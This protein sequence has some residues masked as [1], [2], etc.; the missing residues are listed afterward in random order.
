[1]KVVLL[2]LFAVLFLFS[3]SPSTKIVKS[4]RD[5]GT[6]I[7]PDGNR[8]IYVVAMVK[9]EGSRRVIEDE[10]VSRLKKG[11]GVA[12][13][14]TLTPDVMKNQGDSTSLGIMLRN[15]QYTDVILMRLVDVEKELSYVPGNTSGFYGGYGYYYGYSAM[16]YSTPGYYTTDK[17]YTVETTVYSVNPDKLVWTGTT[18]T[19]NPSNTKKAINDI[20]TVVTEQMKKDGFLLKK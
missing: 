6:T 20:A 17:N 15:G 7:A 13:Y 2:P 14:T 19:L 5:P 9:D 11:Q 1:M 18:T 3:C 4:W 8:K 12:S 16:M 10:I